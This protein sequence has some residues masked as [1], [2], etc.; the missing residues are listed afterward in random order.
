MYSV[1]QIWFAIFLSFFH[2][3]VSS[4]SCS[5]FQPSIND[6]GLFS[7]PL[8]FFAIMNAELQSIEFGYALVVVIVAGVV[9][10]NALESLLN[11]WLLKIKVY[12]SCLDCVA[13]RETLNLNGLCHLV[14]SISIRL[15][16]LRNN[17]WIN[18]YWNWRLV[19][20]SIGAGA[21]YR[22]LHFLIISAFPL[23]SRQNWGKRQ[24]WNIITEDFG[25]L[26]MC[27]RVNGIFDCRQ[28]EF[29]HFCIYF[30]NPSGYFH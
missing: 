6:A 28:A 27:L 15:S 8:V 11:K 7:L 19:D 9:T 17:L 20:S 26:C 23:R 24:K 13:R 10:R 3:P 30:S 5:S 21:M 4:S 18:M 2:Y 29:T 16:N 22:L 12:E 25:T 14:D 1:S